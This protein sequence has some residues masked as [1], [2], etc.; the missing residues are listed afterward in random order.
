MNQVVFPMRDAS[1]N[2]AG[3]AVISIS[4]LRIEAKADGVW[5]EIVKGVSFDLKKGEV[6]G[7]VG[8]S[9]AGK[10]TVGLAA[11][12][13]IRHGCRFKSG[14][15]IFDGEDVVTMP[16][17]RKRHLRSVRIA[18]VAQSAAVSFNP[19]MRLMDQIV[20]AAVSRGG[21][22]RRA[23]EENAKILFRTMRLPDP[24]EFGTRYPHQVSGGQLQRAMVAMAMIC[25]PDLIVFDEPTTALDVTTQV[26]VLVSV[27]EAVR[28]F[29]VAAIYITH[30]LAIVAQMADRVMVLRNGEIVEEGNVSK[31]LSN[32]EHPYTRSLWAVHDFPMIESRNATPLLEIERLNASYGSF[33]VLRDVTIVIGQGQTVALVGESGSG[34]TTL[35]RI[36]AGLMSPKSGRLTFKGGPCAPHIRQRS[37]ELLRKIQIIYQSAET[38]LN[39]RHSVRKIIGRPLKFYHGLTG[40]AQT[41]RILELLTMVELSDSYIDRL[42][43]QLSGGQRQRIAIARALAADPELIVCDEITS[44]LDQVVQADILKMLLSLQRKLGVSYL[45]I[46]HDLA[47]VRAIADD[48]V[49]MHQGRVVEQ[50]PKDKVLNPPHEP[51]TQLLLASAPEMVEGWLDKFTSARATAHPTSMRAS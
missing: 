46:T 27:R 16:E 12:G 26:E 41:R 51:Y 13:Y 22:E 5:T 9:G 42:P 28:Q 49:V 24:E 38:A 35:G 43:A 44:A 6:L 31:M 47:T 40:A 25:K 32:P 34:K 37:K 2:N 18:Y 33:Q 20:E 19:A 7:L 1:W 17:A 30:D 48:I 14:S 39:P 4:G 23:A 45:F 15:I 21:Q 11:L 50:G 3:N 36:V 29:G 10:S 8:E